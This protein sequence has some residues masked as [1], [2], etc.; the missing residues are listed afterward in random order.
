MKQ[1]GYREMKTK[2]TFVASAALLLAVPLV[3]EN[4]NGFENFTLSRSDFKSNPSSALADFSSRTHTEDGRVLA[5]F[6]S[7][8]PCGTI[9]TIR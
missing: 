9:L 4:V 6:S 2:Q 1:K 7:R 8:K 5:S 3:A